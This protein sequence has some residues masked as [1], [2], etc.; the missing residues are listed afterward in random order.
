M[1]P[2]KYAGRVTSVVAPAVLA[3]GVA[4][5]DGTAT[6]TGAGAGAGAGV[7]VGRAAGAVLDGD[8]T[9]CVAA[10]GTGWLPPLPDTPQTT[11]P[12]RATE[13]AA[14]AGMSQRR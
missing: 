11:A 5:G 13:A 1:A 6:A 12:S 9:A 8:V 14:A 10:R 4:A 7:G 3:L 2:T